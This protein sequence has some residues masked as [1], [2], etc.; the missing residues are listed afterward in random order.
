MIRKTLVHDHDALRAK[1]SYV[2]V[3]AIVLAAEVCNA[4]NLIDSSDET[5]A[6][7]REALSKLRAALVAIHYDYG[8]VVGR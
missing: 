4:G 7:D 6:V 3:P 5:E 1:P 2:L 8:M